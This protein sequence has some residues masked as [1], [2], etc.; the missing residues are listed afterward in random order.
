MKRKALTEKDI[1]AIAAG[2]PLAAGEPEVETDV[3]VEPEAQAEEVVEAVAEEVV[4]AQA[5][6]PKVDE[7]LRVLREQLKAASD[8]LLEAKIESRRHAEKV[9]ELE[10]VIG[11][12]SK[13][14]GKSI[15]NM[16]VALGGSA[17]SGEGMAASA[18]VAEHDRVAEQF[19][20]R[21]KAGG[22]AAVSSTGGEKKSDKKFEMDSVFAAR[23]NAVRGK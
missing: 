6:V 14:V 13:I 17:F 4:E 22:V 18:L 5:E 3:V 7:G 23:I 16:Q 20:K 12:M 1:A 11:P 19:L 9:A 8:E 2:V 10:A 21:I 15:S